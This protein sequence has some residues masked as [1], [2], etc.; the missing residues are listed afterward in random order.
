MVEGCMI[1]SIGVEHERDLERDDG[2]PDAELLIY[3][4]F[5]PGC[6]E[7]G[8]SYASGGEPAAPAEVDFDHVEQLA[9]GQWTAAPEFN[10]WARTYLQNDGYDEA[11]QEAAERS[12]PDP[13]YAYERM[14]DERMERGR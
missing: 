8:P 10:D 13:D 7:T 5:V 4:T 11:C 14:R 6:P 2:L 9:D 12:Q 1:F 3:F